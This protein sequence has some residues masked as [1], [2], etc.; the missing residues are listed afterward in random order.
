MDSEAETSKEN[1]KDNKFFYNK[2]LVE[3]TNLIL[4]IGFLVFLIFK[5]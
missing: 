1:Y 2:E 5:K 3:T 4:G